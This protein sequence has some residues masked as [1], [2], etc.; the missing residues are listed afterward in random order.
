ML[1]PGRV[2]L[3]SDGG[4]RVRGHSDSEAVLRDEHIWRSAYV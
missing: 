3:H 4:F 2:S 1:G